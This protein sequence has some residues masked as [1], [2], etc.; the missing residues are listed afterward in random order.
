MLQDGNG[1]NTDGYE[2]RPKAKDQPPQPNQWY[3]QYD[4]N[5][6][7]YVEQQWVVRPCEAK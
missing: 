2:K 4:V 6:I 7:Y 5:I 1:A 3:E